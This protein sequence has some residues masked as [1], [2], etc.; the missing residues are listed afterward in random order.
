[1]AK[2]F[3]ML[4]VGFNLGSSQATPQARDPGQGEKTSQST[5]TPATPAAATL[6]ATPSGEFLISPEDVLEVYIYDV[7]E[8]SRE[9]TV[10]A[11]GTIT[12]PLLPRPVQAAGLSP[13]EFARTLEAVFRQTGRLSHAQITVSIKQSRRSVV[14]VEGAVR[15]PQVVA[16][17][18]PTRLISVL[19][20]CGGRTDDAGST[21][22]VT[23]GELALHDLAL[24]GAPASPTITVEFKKLMDV[25]D[26][27]SKFE[28]WPGDRVSVEQA[29][30]FYVLG[31]VIRPGGYNL[32]NAHE[33]VTV[34]EAFAI[35]GDVTPIA[36]LSQAM[37]IRRNPKAPYGR[38]EITVNVKDI[39][40]GR[41]PDRVLQA[42]D[43]LFVPASSGKRT[44]RAAGN[45]A[46]SLAN[47]AGAAA[48]YTRF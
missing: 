34:L 25:N 38:E 23:R 9:Y 35:A 21:I 39:I 41:S 37:I 7:P 11:A 36:K 22:T 44:L 14:T 2:L 1:M 10:N 3:L 12:V 43:I 32:K 33:I 46:V 16:V 6:Q 17:T 26:P 48:I 15:S 13:E 5:S 47:A 27:T 42:Y 24:K 31:Q 4:A 40:Y 19:S 29:G 45:V 8:L 30:L 18:G 28:V 20:Q